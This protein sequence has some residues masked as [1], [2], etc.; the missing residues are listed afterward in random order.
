MQTFVPG[1]DYSS[2]GIVHSYGL[3]LERYEN[4]NITVFITVFGHLGSGATHSAFFGFDVDRVPVGILG[5]RSCITP[6]PYR[7]GRQMRRHAVCIRATSSGNTGLALFA[8]A[9]GLANGS[10]DGSVTPS[11][12]ALLLVVPATMAVCALVA[13]VPSCAAM[14]TSLPTCPWNE[15]PA[16][17]TPDVCLSGSLECCASEQSRPVVAKDCNDGGVTNRLGVLPEEGQ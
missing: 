2:F 11:P 7:N 8:I 5:S 12:V 9:H 14:T 1:E 15:S 10:S 17:A 16:R 4:D 3:G 6:R 13:S